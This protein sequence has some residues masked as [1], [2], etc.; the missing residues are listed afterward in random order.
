[1]AQVEFLYEQR[2]SIIQCNT[3]EKLKKISEQFASKMNININS[4]CFLCDGQNIDLDSTYDE[5]QKDKESN[6]LTIL[7]FPMN[8][9]NENEKDNNVIIKSNS[10]IC[11]KCRENTRFTIE[12][13]LINL[14]DCK[15]G[16]K[17]NYILL[18]EF[19]KEQN[20]NISKIICGKC[21]EYNKG[22][23]YENKFY[24][25][26]TCRINLCPL[27]KSSHDAKH[28]IINYE[29]KNFI[30]HKH[31]EALIMYCYDC[32]LNLCLSCQNMHKKHK[33]IFFGDISPEIY[34]IENEMKKLR[35]T[36]DIFNT[37]TNNIINQMK[38]VMDNLEIYYKICDDIFK[39]YI[40][41][42]RNYELWQN[43]NELNNNC[44]RKEIN[45]INNDKSIGNKVNN[46][47]DIYN[48][49]INNQ[50]NITYNTNNKKK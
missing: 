21:K 32:K 18:D 19:E 22:N 11:P 13:Y 33:T 24:I 49:M 29:D 6:S 47:I 38:K 17:I 8:N 41:K 42:N 39:N 44:I 40:N 14:Y 2:R 45:N 7:A 26:C 31:N 37:D 5:L 1:M 25:C 50:I 10:I 27:C 43:L 16:H 20:I 28:N 30:C 15:N 36:I 12:D 35:K 23:T 48:K 9:S 4:T 34:K 3:N 46:I